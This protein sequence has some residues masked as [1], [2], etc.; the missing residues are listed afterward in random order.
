LSEGDR[1]HFYHGI[2]NA[3]LRLLIVFLP[4]DQIRQ[5]VG[6]VRA[7]S[8][9]QSQFLLGLLQTDFRQGNRSIEV[10]PD[11]TAGHPESGRDAGADDGCPRE[12]HHLIVFVVGH[13]IHARTFVLL[14]NR[15]I[16]T[17]DNP[18]KRERKKRS[19]LGCG[20]SHW[21][22]VSLHLSTM[23]ELTC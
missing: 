11:G 3:K 10:E 1:Y 15:R 8:D 16:A 7:P 18:I 17:W 13:A 14:D 12:P 6:H 22:S 2:Q 21:I 19:G 5:L 20:S 4:Q 23:L 9:F